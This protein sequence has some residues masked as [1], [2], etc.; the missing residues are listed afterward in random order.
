MYCCDD[1]K[2]CMEDLAFVS[3]RKDTN[4]N[5]HIASDNIDILTIYHCPFCGTKLEEE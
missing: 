5:Y 4:D 3:I 2:E 1:L